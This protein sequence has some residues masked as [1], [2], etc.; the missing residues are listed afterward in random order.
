MTQTLS[1]DQM[2]EQMRQESARSNEARKSQSRLLLRVEEME[3]E[4]E[5]KRRQVLHNRKSSSRGDDCEQQLTRGLVLAS[6]A[7]LLQSDRRVLCAE[8]KTSR[9]QLEEERERGRRLEELCGQLEEQTGEQC[10]RVQRLFWNNR[11]MQMTDNSLT[12][13][14]PVKFKTDV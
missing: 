12:N 14:L 8:V 10:Q 5:L 11:S 4:A 7:E 13:L 3:A 1:N 2:K 9:R 6:Q